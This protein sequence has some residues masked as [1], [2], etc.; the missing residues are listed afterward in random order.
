MALTKKMLVAMDI[1]AEKI[2]EIMSNHLASIDVL[3][4][5]RDGFKADAEKLASVEK[6]LEQAKADLEKFKAGDW[7]KK[8]TDIKAEYDSYK[9]DTETKAVKAAKEAAYRTL[10]IDSGI[11]EKRVASVMKVS[12]IDAV[13][14]DADGVIKDA[15]KL[16]ESIKTE[17]ADFIATE[18]KKGADTATPPVGDGETKA[19]SVARQLAEQYQREHYGSPAKSSKED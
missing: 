17:W 3:R 1:P 9:S 18:G 16:T 4:E 10:L 14:L 11:S 13:E 15:E 5:E 8:Y 2:D 6:E 19:P 7:E 12:D